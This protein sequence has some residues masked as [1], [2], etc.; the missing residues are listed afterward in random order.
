MSILNWV[1]LEYELRYSM[2]V[3]VRVQVHNTYLFLA[4]LEELDC[5]LALLL[6][7]L[8]EDLE[9]LDG[10]EGGQLVLVLAVDHPQ[11]LVRVGQDVQNEWG[12][13]LKKL[14]VKASG[15]CVRHVVM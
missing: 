1:T 3:L 4:V 6:E 2:C 10:V 7:V 8:D 12:R 9:V 13:I 5:L 15:H 14:I 11:V